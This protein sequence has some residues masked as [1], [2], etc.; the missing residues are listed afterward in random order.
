VSRGFSRVAVKTP[1][2]VWDFFEYLTQE[3]WE[4]EQAKAAFVHSSSDPYVY[5]SEPYHQDQFRG[6]CF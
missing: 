2:E 6:P 4:F 1:D 5:H 3:T